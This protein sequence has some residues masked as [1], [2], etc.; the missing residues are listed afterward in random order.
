MKNIKKIIASNG[1]LASLR[2]SY[3]LDFLNLDESYKEKDLRK[4]IVSRLKNFI[5]EYGH[6]FTFVCEEYHVQ[7]GNTDFFIDLLFYNR[8]L[9][10]LVAVDLKIDVFRPEHLGRLNF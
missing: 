9:S 5:L 1:G 6:D 4:Q 7:V 8:Y 3:V 10:C 2:V